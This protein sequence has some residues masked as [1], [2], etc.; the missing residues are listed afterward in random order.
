V[1]SWNVLLLANV[2]PVAH[3]I[4]II[5]FMKELLFDRVILDPADELIVRVELVNDVNAPTVAPDTA[6]I[7][8]LFITELDPNVL[9]AP[10]VPMVHPVKIELFPKV[11]TV[12]GAIKVQFVNMALL[13]KATEVSNKLIIQSIKD[14]LLPNE[15]VLAGKLIIQFTNDILAPID[16]VE[17]AALIV[18]LENCMSL[19]NE[20]IEIPKFN[21]ASFPLKFACAEY[22][23]DIDGDVNIICPLIFTLVPFVLLDVFAYDIKLVNWEIQELTESIVLNCPSVLSMKESVVPAYPLETNRLASVI[24]NAEIA[25]PVTVAVT[26]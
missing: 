23:N 22:P 5:Q 18:I 8:Q 16:R 14:T 10:S 13:P 1:Q 9:N 19:L 11:I 25:V 24:V 3:D 15:T 21:I 26:I 12:F 6:V 17:L 4:L 7:V 2:K 20:T